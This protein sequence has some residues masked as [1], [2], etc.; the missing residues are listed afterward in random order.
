MNR[1]DLSNDG[2]SRWLEAL[3]HAAFEY[4]GRDDFSY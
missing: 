3:G 4:P 1:S 2:V